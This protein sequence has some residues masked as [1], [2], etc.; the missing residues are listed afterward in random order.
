MSNGMSDIQMRQ[1]MDHAQGVTG[2]VTNDPITQDP[3]DP[4]FNYKNSNVNLT[5]KNLLPFIGAFLIYKFL[6]KM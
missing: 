6:W 1:I 2:T 3:V 5:Y 4:I